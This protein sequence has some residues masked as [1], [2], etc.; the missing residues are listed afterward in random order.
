MKVVAA[1]MKVAAAVVVAIK[2]VAAA[3]AAMNVAAADVAAL[4]AVHRPLHARVQ[5]DTYA[6]DRV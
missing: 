6:R 1:A 5:K 3:G 4:G 2:V